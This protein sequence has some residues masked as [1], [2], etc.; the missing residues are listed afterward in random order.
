[1]TSS[2]FGKPTSLVENQGVWWEKINKIDQSYVH[3]SDDAFIGL[4]SEKKIPLW[5]KEFGKL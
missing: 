2:L 1:M 4:E 3:L 5:L